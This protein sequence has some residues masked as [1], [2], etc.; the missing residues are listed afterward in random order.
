M[1]VW[2]SFKCVVCYSDVK[3]NDVEM[4]KQKKCSVHVEAPMEEQDRALWAPNA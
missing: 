4:A 2:S 1:P 3:T